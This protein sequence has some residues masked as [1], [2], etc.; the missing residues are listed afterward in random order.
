ML[1]S[2]LKFLDVKIENKTDVPLYILT[3][4]FCIC[5]V[6]REHKDPLVKM[7]L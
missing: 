7:D 3:I 6:Q 5:R 2:R 1:V 4:V